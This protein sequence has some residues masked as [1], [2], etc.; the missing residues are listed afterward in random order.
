MGG[1]VFTSDASMPRSATLIGLFVKRIRALL[2]E[3]P[4]R[5]ALQGRIVRCRS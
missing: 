4:D 5:E 3:H 1:L 2:D